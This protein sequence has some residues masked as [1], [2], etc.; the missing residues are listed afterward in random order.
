MNEVLDDFGAAH[1]TQNMVEQDGTE[2]L[3]AQIQ[4]RRR[5]HFMKDPAWEPANGLC[6]TVF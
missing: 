2:A 6:F 3:S 5:Y 4:H 1:V